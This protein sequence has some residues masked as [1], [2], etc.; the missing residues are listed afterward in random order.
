ML[1][2]IVEWFYHDLAGLGCDPDGPGWRKIIIQP[3]PAGNLAWARAS[4]NS[5]QGRVEAGWERGGHEFRL[6]IRVPVNT[7]ATVFVPAK[8]TTSISEEGHR[9][10]EA[11]GVR[12]LRSETEYVVLA[13]ESGTYRL[14]SRTDR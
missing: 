14:V 11:Q 12:V 5:V 4:Y 13:V 9:I 1:G 10:D 6:N 3:H 8:S 7:T 2:H